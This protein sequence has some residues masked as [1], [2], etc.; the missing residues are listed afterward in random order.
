MENIHTSDRIREKSYKPNRDHQQFII[1]RLTV[2]GQLKKREVS[3]V[4]SPDIT[5]IA[6]TP[7]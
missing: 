1:L 3:G 7:D 5:K 2:V 4:L 6:L